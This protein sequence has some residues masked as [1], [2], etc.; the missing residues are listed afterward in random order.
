MDRK[1]KQENDDF[2][3]DYYWEKNDFPWWFFMF[4][5]SVFFSKNCFGSMVKVGDVSFQPRRIQKWV[6]SAKSVKQ[7]QKK[8]TKLFELMFFHFLGTH[9]KD[10]SKEGSSNVSSSF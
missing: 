2:T 3:L 5:S 10:R 9:Y 8:K 7:K 1:K 6:L 4:F